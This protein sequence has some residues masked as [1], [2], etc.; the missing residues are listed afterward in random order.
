MVIPL[1]YDVAIPAVRV[2]AVGIM[3]FVA[4]GFLVAVAGHAGI[5]QAGF[6]LAAVARDIHALFV[7][8]RLIPPFNEQAHMIGA[9]PLLR[10]DAGSSRI[11][12]LTVD[13]DLPLGQ[14]DFRIPVL[15]RTEV[16]PERHGED[17][18]EDR[19][20]GDDILCANQS[21]ES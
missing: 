21:S 12:G 9:H 19:K 6:P 1:R 13:H 10:F 16:Q 4:E 17:P 14:S 5:L 18:H 11:H 20:A 2:H 15:F 3:A 8:Q 7:A